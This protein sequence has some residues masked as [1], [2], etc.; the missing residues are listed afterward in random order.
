[1]NNQ[2][3]KFRLSR[4]TSKGGCNQGK[5]TLIELLVVIAIIAILAALLL[6]ALSNA[7]RLAKSIT[8]TANLKQVLMASNF[9]LSDY[10]EYFPLQA[11]DVVP[12]AKN[13]YAWACKFVPY[14]GN[15]RTLTTAE[16][17]AMYQNGG[18]QWRFPYVPIKVFSCPEFPDAGQEPNGDIWR[19]C[20]MQFA[21]YRNAS[22]K[23]QPQVIKDA[24]NKTRSWIF[25]E[26]CNQPNANAGYTT[27]EGGM[28]PHRQMGMSVNAALHDGSVA[29]RL[30]LFYKTKSGGYSQMW[31]PE[32][33]Q[34]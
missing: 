5:F 20:G 31:L 30:K 22:G 32:M 24:K 1:M 29:S 28:C 11:G 21:M 13:D 3:R 15:Y 4:S 12:I 18:G 2:L 8:C 19:E 27:Y 17:K 34:N 7:R 10:K 33:Y 23:K 14:L 9:Y 16:N 25:G 6:P 26:T